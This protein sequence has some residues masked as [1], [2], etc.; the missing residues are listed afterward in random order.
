MTRVTVRSRKYRSWEMVTTVPRKERIYSSSHSVAW[1][2]RWLVG[3]SSSRMSVSSRMRRPRFTRVFSPPERLVEQLL[4]RW[5][6]GMD[7]PLATLFT[8]TSVS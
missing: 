7:R 3:S 6:S 5:L 4:D 1:R 2:S 8:A